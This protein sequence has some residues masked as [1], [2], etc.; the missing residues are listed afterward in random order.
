MNLKRWL[1]VFLAGVTLAIGQTGSSTKSGTGN[2]GSTAS[3]KKGGLIDINS[4][5]AEELDS[6][7]GIGPVMAQKIIAGRPYR[8]KTD[9]VTRKI[10]PQSAYDKIKGQ[11][12]AHQKK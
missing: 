11:I 8:A 9:L 10:I 5:S 4:A 3:D 1:L 6:L 2:T 7:P 12:I